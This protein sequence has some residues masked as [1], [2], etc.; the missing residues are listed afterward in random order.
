MSEKNHC[1]K[2][3]GYSKDCYNCFMHNK[4]AALEAENKDLTRKGEELCHA[5]GSALMAIHEKDRSLEIVEKRWFKDH[6]FDAYEVRKA[7]AL[8][9]NSIQSRAQ[10]QA[11]LIEAAKEECVCWYDTCP[12]C[13]KVLDAA[14][15]LAELEGAK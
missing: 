4:V 5:Y 11:R 10:A 9:P 7:L 15:A 12:R 2:H 8:T 1:P 14:A 3:E 13:I 6:V